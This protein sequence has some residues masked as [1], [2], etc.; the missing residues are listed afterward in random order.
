MKKRT[1]YV[2]G[3][4]MFV[5]NACT[6]HNNKSDAYGN[7]ESDEVTVSSETNGRI[8]IANINEGTKVSKGE[9]LAE[10]DTAN[11]GLQKA[12][13]LSQEQSVLAQKAGLN[14]QI[15][16]TDQQIKNLQVDQSR[17]QKMFKEGAS[18][19]KQLDDISGQIA[20]AEKQKKAFAAQISAIDKNAGAVRAQSSVISDQIK[21]SVVK[22]PISG[23]VLEKY[24]EPGELATPGKPLYKITN[25]DT[26]KLR[27]YVSGKQLSQIKTGSPVKVLID[28][29]N[30]IK[31]LKGS[32]EWISSEAE[33]TPKIIQTR[34]ER[35]K[36]VYAVKVRVPNDG[37]LK[38][39][40]PGEIKF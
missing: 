27:V 5:L 30:G 28:E 12:Q 23:T 16:V 37:T 9:I 29:E 40:M 20:L 33:F 25:L 15:A 6:E 21:R 22:S 7:F 31:E 11:L 19:Q 8:I 1:V 2:I 39:G 36:L 34:E 26:L 4:L 38:L 17:L 3:I 18:T 13:L 24:V 32:V 35:V 10:I 14:A